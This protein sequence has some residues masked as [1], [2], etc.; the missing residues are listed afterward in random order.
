MRDPFARIVRTA[1]LITVVLAGSAC[2][3]FGPGEPVEKITELPRNLTVAEEAVITGGNDFGL[4]LLREMAVRDDRPN[5]ILSPLSASMALGMTLNGA[6]GATY[7]AMRST[8]GFDDLSRAEINDSYAGLIDLLT[9]LDRTVTF[10]IANAVW[11]NASIP[12]HQSFLDAVRAS[13]RAEAASRS[14]TDPATLT[15]IND[16]VDSNT[17]GRIT[18]ILDSLDPSLVALLVNAI[19][20]KGSWTNRFDPAD[21]RDH[22]FMRENG[23][24]V[25]VPMMRIADVELPYGS[26]DGWRAV[27]LPYGGEAFSMVLVEPHDGDARALATRLDVGLWQEIVGSLAPMKIDAVSMPKF[28][29]DYDVFLNDALRAMGMDPA[30]RPGADFTGMSPSGD[31][32]CI[33]FVRQK[34]FL[35]VD[36]EGTEAAAVTAVGA[37][38]VSFFGVSLDRP[39][40]FAIR[41]RLSGTILFAG[42]IGDPTFE[43]T[44]PP[45][46]EVTCR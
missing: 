28:E 15:E 42:V 25:V 1:S 41:E 17:N 34:T 24:P 43:D 8:L 21:T 14:F 38:L 46:Y 20:F 22:E 6:E 44:A 36:E 29:L 10:D 13:F 16:W 45:A 40:L 2:D 26:G 12:I 30:F 5:L 11:T 23:R 39:F 19:Y 35:K 27:E 9:R 37:R 31:R 7:E 4:E 3:V 32:I 33:D 18:E